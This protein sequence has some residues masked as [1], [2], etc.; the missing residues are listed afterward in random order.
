MMSVYSTKFCCIKLV[1][2]KNTVKGGFVSLDKN[3]YLIAKKWAL[4]FGI[5][6]VVV[7]FI[8]GKG[9]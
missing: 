3:M 9:L 2:L 5:I 8:T 1:Y 6:K 4:T 7:K